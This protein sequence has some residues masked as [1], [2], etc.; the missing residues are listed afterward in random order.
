M[1]KITFIT[2]IFLTLLL[3]GCASQSANVAGE[4]ISNDAVPQRE[5]IPAAVVV[6]PVSNS[7]HMRGNLYAPV[8]IIIYSDFECSFCARFESAS[9]SIEQAKKE[10]GDS[11]RFVF[12]HYP[13]PFHAE[14]AKAAEASECASAQGK[15]WEMHDLLFSDSA[16][17][18]LSVAQ[19][20]TNAQTLGLDTAAFNECLDSGKYSDTI[21]QAAVDAEKLGVRGTP[22]AFV[23]GRQVIGAIPY[24]D[25]QDETGVQ[26]GLKTI[27]QQAL[28]K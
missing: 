25:Y 12:R 3:S 23:N 13:L 22:N 5:Q 7:D 17:G 19:S 11:L 9:G 28:G 27:I 21:T 24:E 15:F 4:K 16:N 14:A 8:T 20:K 10:F 26:P 18:R 1:Q 2:F 6:P